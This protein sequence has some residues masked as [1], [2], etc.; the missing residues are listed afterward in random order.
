M[1]VNC[2]QVHRITP[3]RNPK[4]SLPRID[5][6]TGGKIKIDKIGN[7]GI[8]L[9]KGK[10]YDMPKLLKASTVPYDLEA[11][12]KRCDLTQEKAAELLGVSTS[13]LWRIEKTGQ[14]S[15]ETLWAC[16]GVERYLYDQRTGVTP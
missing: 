8:T 9:N 13:K 14:A 16:Y 5:F 7:L 12:R 11:W 4:R 15:K 10:V 6:A 1:D 3:C 2:I